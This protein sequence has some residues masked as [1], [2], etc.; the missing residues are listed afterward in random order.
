MQISMEYSASAVNVVS[1]NPC[2]ALLPGIKNFLLSACV[3]ELLTT[4]N[5]LLPS[6]L[7]SDN[8]NVPCESNPVPSSE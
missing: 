1:S 5:I 7:P 8:E 3:E 2:I 4:P 6:L